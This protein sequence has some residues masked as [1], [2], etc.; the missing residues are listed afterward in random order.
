MSDV[1]VARAAAAHRGLT[2][3]RRRSLAPVEWSARLAYAVG[4]IAT[5]GC[6][7]KDGRHVAFVTK[8]EDL[9]RTWLTC[10]GHE[11]LRYSRPISR[12]GTTIYR[13][14][15][16]DVGL[17]RFLISIGLTPRKSLTLGR[18]DVPD[19]FF[20]DFVRGLLDGD[21]SIYLRRHRP[22]RRTYPDYW[23]TRL[24]TY[25][26]SGSETHVRWLQDQLMRRHGI[27]GWI[28]ATERK[29]RHTFYRLRFGNADSMTL[30][31]ALYR[32]EGAPHLARKKEKWL[33]FLGRS[34]EGGI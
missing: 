21:G 29:G 14:Q 26:S 34:A 5:D 22:T 10:I 13:I 8:D 7:V 18:V 16:S 25:F 27:T 28:E 19:R 24:W 15:V 4:L 3:T 2:Y 1:R 12:T 6:L 23:Y 30:L 11:Q 32:E 9:M 31:S 33:R 17:Y 20:D